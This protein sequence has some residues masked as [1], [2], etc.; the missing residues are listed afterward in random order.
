MNN[1]TARTL[2][3]PLA[4]ATVL[5]LTVWVA[6]LER[7]GTRV[8]T[9][10]DTASYLEPGRNLLLHGRFWTAGLPE[11]GRTPG[12]PL[13]LALVS[14][15]G[16]A[17]AS[18]AQVAVSVLCVVLVWRLVRAMGA[19]ERTAQGAAWLLAIESASTVYAARLLSETLF[20]AVLLLALE[21]MAGFVRTRELRRVAW[22]GVWLAAAIFVR[23]VAYYL[24]AVWAVG[25]VVICWS[26]RRIRWKAPALFLLA[27]VPWMAAWQVR[28]RVE[29]GYTGFSSVAV[30][31]LYFY[32]AAEVEARVEGVSFS[33]MQRSFGYPDEAAY[34]ASHPEQTEWSEAAK[35]AFMQQEAGRT[36]RAHWP[37]AL[38]TQLAGSV[39]VIFTPCAAE[40]LEMLGEDSGAAPARVVHSGPLRAAWQVARENPG[41]A[42]V[43]AAFEV[44]LLALYLLA[45]RELRRKR[46][47]VPLV[48]LLLGTAFYFVAV[49]GGVQAVG[50]FRV[51]LMPM[52]CV[53]AA[54]G[55]VREPSGES[56]PRY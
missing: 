38:R 22:S 37:E 18:L 53:L 33:Q 35:L 30:R 39:V 43:M 34:R 21:Q 19:S 8:L 46:L 14:G 49:S 16:P 29:T 5:R 17:V 51:P 15:L 13:F 55:L 50:R 4:V 28:N 32:S 23:P 24:P 3:A 56:G 40:L 47:Q 52:I 44:W 20:C 54:T 42:V 26:D 31:N 36:L 11:I 27:T 48:A 12:Y 7:T 1:G 45:V 2:A 10:G 6:A 41:N 9:A 25:L